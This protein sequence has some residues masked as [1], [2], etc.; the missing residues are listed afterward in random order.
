MPSLSSEDV[1]E[2]ACLAIGV[3][4]MLAEIVVVAGSRHPCEAKTG[5]DE[6]HA[7]D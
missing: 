4:L 1:A 3:I 2:L 5:R 7:R 6:A